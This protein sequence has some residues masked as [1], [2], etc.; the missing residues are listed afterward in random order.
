[1]EVGLTEPPPNK[2]QIL[3]AYRQNPERNNHANAT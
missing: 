2:E 1:V 3:L